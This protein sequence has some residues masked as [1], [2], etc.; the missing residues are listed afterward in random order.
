MTGFLAEYDRIMEK[1]RDEYED[2]SPSDYSG[3]GYNTYKRMEKDKEDY[4]LFLRD[5]FVPPTN[6]LAEHYGR[7]FKRKSHQVMAFRSKD[8]VNHFCDGLMIM[9]TLKAKRKNL[10]VHIYR[11]Y[12]AIVKVLLLILS[13]SWALLFGRKPSLVSTN[14]GS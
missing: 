7:K 10:Y 13:S 3:D 14:F 4:A 6:N 5:P 11:P 8:G 12:I 2:E 9:E 1:A